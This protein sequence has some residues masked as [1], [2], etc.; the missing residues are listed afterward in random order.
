MSSLRVLRAILRGRRAG[1]LRLRP[2]TPETKFECLK[3]DC[4]RC[5]RVF[6]EG[7]VA[8]DLGGI[9]EPSVLPSCGGVCAFLENGLCSIYDTRPRGC[10][11]Y[12]WYNVDGRLYYDSGCPGFATGESDPP[13]IGSIQKIEKYFPLPTM[14]QSLIIRLIKVW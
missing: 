13:Q 12:P 14:L 11:E 4:A 2:A 9:S 3:A 5:C 7:I 10:S 1:L 6:G 8:N